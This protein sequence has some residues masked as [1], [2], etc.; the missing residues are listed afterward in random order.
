MYFK[1]YILLAHEEGGATIPFTHSL[2]LSPPLTPPSCCLCFTKTSAPCRCSSPV[3]WLNS[4]MSRALKKPSR[5]CFVPR[6]RWTA[7]QS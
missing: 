3:R 6:Q 1:N 7:N 2:T 5:R 4:E